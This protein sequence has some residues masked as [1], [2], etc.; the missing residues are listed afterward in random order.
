MALDLNEASG[1][2]V[3]AQLSQTLSNNYTIA[4]W[5]N[6]RSGGAFSNPRVAVLSSALCGAS[7]EFL[8]TSLTTN[9]A[10]PQFLEL[11]RCSQFDGPTSFDPIPLNQWVHV[12]V[13]VSP[14]LGS[15]GSVSNLVRFYLNGSP[16]GS[17]L[18]TNLN[19][20]I[21]PLVHL[22]LNWLGRKFDGLLDQVQVWGTAL[23]PTSI[24]LVMAQQLTGIPAID[25]ALMLSFDFD[26]GTGNLVQG[27]PG[28][29][30]LFGP[31]NWVPSANLFQSAGTVTT[32][33]AR[34]VAANSAVLFGDFSSFALSSL[35]R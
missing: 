14:A 12:A 11:G 15:G 34:N 16:A 4:A 25:N 1:N 29:G 24:P 28:T 22:G 7:T 6:L 35:S 23:A 3:S 13:S 19:L 26:E 27:F 2:F 10:D 32:R 31:V 17:S 33:P 9:S 30:T 8:I 18:V 5:I 21:G 20:S